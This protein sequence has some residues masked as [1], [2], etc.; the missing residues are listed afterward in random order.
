MQILQKIFKKKAR[1]M[2]FV[3]SFEVR[4]FLGMVDLYENY[5][6]AMQSWSVAKDIR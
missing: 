3:T 4:E 6:G 2:G 5:I 1:I